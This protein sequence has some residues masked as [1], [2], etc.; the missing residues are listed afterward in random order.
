MYENPFL[1]STTLQST[2]TRSNTYDNA[3][4]H[5]N[6]DN[7]NVLET[8]VMTMVGVSV[9]LP[10]LSLFPPSLSLCLS[11]PLLPP[12]PLPPLLKSWDVL[13]NVS[14]TSLCSP[15]EHQ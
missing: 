2:T 3:P 4:Q 10:F 7:T 1:M 5:A 8:D 13:R 11:L 9:Y 12:L 14:T 6:Y 15:Y